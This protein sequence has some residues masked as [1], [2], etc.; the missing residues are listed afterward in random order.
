MLRLAILGAGAFVVALVPA[1]MVTAFA[2]GV[3]W[4]F[5]YGDN[6]WP[7]AADLTILG[8]FFVSWF[9]A[10]SAL[11]SA[12]NRNP[13]VQRFSLGQLMVVSVMMGTM[14]IG[15]MLVHQWLNGN[16]GH[17]PHPC[18]LACEAKGFSGASWSD[19]E[20]GIEDCTCHGVSQSDERP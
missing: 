9:G 5:V 12:L 13:R 6:V 17:E 10:G 19:D 2:A 20:P 16:L 15:V 7:K 1:F 18:K 11:T 14:A 4:L 3:L 8:V